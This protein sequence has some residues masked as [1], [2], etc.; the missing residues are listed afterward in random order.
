MDTYKAII[1]RRSIRKFSQK[2]ISS[3]TLERILES[4]RLSP[5]AGNL[6]PCEFI[7]VNEEKAKD[8]LFSALKWAFYIAPKGNPE[9]DKRPVTY[10]ITIAD[11]KKSASWGLVDATIAMENMILA[12]WSSGV[13]SCWMGA[14]DKERIRQMFAIP[15][16]YSVEFVLAL[17]YPKDRS[18]VE[19]YKGEV[20]YWMDDKG[21]LHVPKRSLS[22]ILHRNKFKSSK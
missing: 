9:R 13:G 18:V 17:G 1:T 16:N 15:S 8:E 19:A 5:S 20:K 14:I 2:P 6:Q 3:A 22:D 11:T 12:A 21:V 10:I 7:V 4:A